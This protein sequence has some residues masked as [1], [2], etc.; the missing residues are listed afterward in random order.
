MRRASTIISAAAA[1]L[2]VLGYVAIRVSE[3]PR[4]VL[5]HALKLEKLPAS[6]ANLR[7][8]ADLWTD[9]VRFF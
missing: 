1:V 8:R 6:V 9:E 7:M 5:R 2:V 4:R 3:S